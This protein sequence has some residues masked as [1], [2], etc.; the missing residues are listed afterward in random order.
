[1]QLR[2][3][4]YATDL[5]I[6]RL[7]GAEVRERERYRVIRSPDQPTYFYGNLL[8]FPAAPER[9]D[10]ER[11]TELF[12]AEFVSDP[13]VRHLTFCWD[14]PSGACG[15]DAPFI[16][17]GYEH[18]VSTVLCA[19]SVHAPPRPLA[20]LVVRPLRGDRDWEAAV[21]CQFATRDEKYESASHLLFVQRRMR[22]Q[23][24][25]VA[26]GA[27]EWY[28][29]FLEGQL[30]GNLGIYVEHGVGR[31]QVVTVTPAFQRR[32]VCGTLVHAAAL[33]AFDVLDARELVMVADPDAGAIRV[34]RSVGFEP[35]ERQASL[36]W[37]PR[38]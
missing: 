12:R 17:A 5:F 25:L 19:T 21:A 22:A 6:L 36:F 32:G 10:F 16:E 29:A 18:E 4:A 20:E 8:L 33:H 2:S 1:M 31:F 23:R 24:A 26:S 34:Y 13:E 14:D 7:A 15:D 28:G 9:G 27:G 35:L 37:F 3:V 38:A 11:W 30:V